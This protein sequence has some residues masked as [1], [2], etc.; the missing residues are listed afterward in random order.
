MITVLYAT[1]IPNRSWQ[2]WQ[3]ADTE[4][5]GF[6]SP[7]GFSVVL[8]LIGHCQA[9]RSADADQALKRTFL[10]KWKRSA[11]TNAVTAG[12][13]PRFDGISL[14]VQ[15]TPQPLAQQT[16]GGSSSGPIRVPP[17]P[18]EKVNE[19]SSLFEKAGAQNG[20]LGGQCSRSLVRQRSLTL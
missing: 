17:L 20:F 15:D 7:A 5:R 19:Y 11:S 13:L 6:L 12:P 14:P 18:P 9:G 3:I 1:W 8:R 4:N 16:S 10:R 2:I